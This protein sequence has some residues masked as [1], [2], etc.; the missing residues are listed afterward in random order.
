MTL[1]E[2]IMSIYPDLTVTDFQTVIHLRNDSDGRGDY[3]ALWNHPA[4]SKPTQEQLD[5]TEKQQ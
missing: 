5:G 4:F 1:Y 2:K 3:I